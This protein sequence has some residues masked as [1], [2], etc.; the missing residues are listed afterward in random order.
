MK[1]VELFG[2]KVDFLIVPAL[3][4]AVIYLFYGSLA[5]VLAFA[6]IAAATQLKP[7]QHSGYSRERLAL[8]GTALVLT[9]SV[10]L[11]SYFFESYCSAA[12]WAVNGGLHAFL[13]MD[14]PC[15][16]RGGYLQY[17]LQDGWR[18]VL[19]DAVM[20]ISGLGL[21][22]IALRRGAGRR[23]GT[24]AACFLLLLGLWLNRPLFHH[25]LVM[26]PEGRPAAANASPETPTTNTLA[27]SAANIPPLP[28]S[29][30]QQPRNAPAIVLG[31]IA[32]DE[33]EEYAGESCAFYMRGNVSVILIPGAGAINVGGETLDLA[34]VPSNYNQLA[35]GGR[36]SSSNFMITISPDFAHE[37]QLDDGAE[38]PAR[39]HVEE[40]GK[41]ATFHGR[42][43]CAA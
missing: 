34:N 29:R 37:R 32:D 5:G 30:R 31:T 18:S 11:R 24:L 43:N 28:S 19:R 16:I 13:R 22:F 25:E 10:F 35:R 36:F 7:L 8:M 20:P 27:V 17:V 21:L 38:W 1:S 40:N 15:F 14:M 39:V 33:L 26:N 42:W 41:T 9:F 6:V 3:S 4:S 12:P 23:N 2:P